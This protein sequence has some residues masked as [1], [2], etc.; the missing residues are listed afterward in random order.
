M[1]TF[2]LKLHV[3]LSLCS[4]ISTFVCL[5]VCATSVDASDELLDSAEWGLC[6]R[7]EEALAHFWINKNPW[8]WNIHHKNYTRVTKPTLL[9]I[10][11]SQHI[12][13]SLRCSLCSFIK[14]VVDGGC[15]WSNKIF[16]KNDWMKTK[17]EIFTPV[18]LC[19][20][21]HCPIS[22][23]GSTSLSKAKLMQFTKIS[24]AHAVLF[25]CL[26]VWRGGGGGGYNACRVKSSAV[27]K[28][29]PQALA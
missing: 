8:V 13:L 5:C 29:L 17:V 10:E 14:K 23:P 15:A 22:V 19:H 2:D 16:K 20:Q 6:I 12:S 21:C 3:C 27:G 25:M 28:G 4:Q 1:G 7:L 18:C 11:G 9:Y 24:S 26:Y